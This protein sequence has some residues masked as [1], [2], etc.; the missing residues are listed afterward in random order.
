M[1]EFISR[2]TL[3]QFI[4]VG[5]FY[6]VSNSFIVVGNASVRDLLPKVDD[7]KV[8]ENS[9]PNWVSEILQVP[10]RSNAPMQMESLW[11]ASK[12]CS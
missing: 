3:F 10:N 8:R 1:T 12:A 9:S 5:T 4:L 6:H 7:E 2:M 11:C